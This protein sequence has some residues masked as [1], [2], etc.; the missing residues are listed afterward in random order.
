MSNE[1]L[2]DF[3]PN[4]ANEANGVKA[5][6]VS[7]TALSQATKLLAAVRKGGYCHKRL[8]LTNGTSS[9]VSIR[10]MKKG[11]PMIS[12]RETDIR[13]V[14]DSRI[15]DMTLVD[16]IDIVKGNAALNRRFKTQRKTKIV[17]KV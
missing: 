4:V 11:P 6:A 2:S 17:S 5:R 12:T 15:R 10:P 9:Y 7:K 16:A 3:S 13:G 1:N 14:S 8:N